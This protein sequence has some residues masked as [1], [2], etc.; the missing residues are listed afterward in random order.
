MIPPPNGDIAFVRAFCGDCD[1]VFEGDICGFHAHAVEQIVFNAFGFQA[2]AHG[3]NG[4][5]IDE[6]GGR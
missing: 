2:L 3:L 1:G 4:G 5:E 6:V